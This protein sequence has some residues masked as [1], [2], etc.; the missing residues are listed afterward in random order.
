VRAACAWVAARA[1]SVRIEEE[2]LERYAAELP[3]DDVR[4]APAHSVRVPEGLEP[5]GVAGFVLVLDAINFGSGY[6]PHLR[7]RPGLSGYQTVEAALREWWEREGAPSPRDLCAMRPEAVAEILGQR[8]ADP[9]ARELMGL[10]AR[11]LRDLGRHVEERH[12]GDLAG[13][14][15]SGKGSAAALVRDLCAMPL[16]L[17]IARYEGRP[18][19][20]LKRAQITAHDLAASV[21]GPL[22]HFEDLAELTIFADNL[23]PHVL[24]LDG[25]LAFA[26]QLEDR[27]ER[28]E[29]LAWGSPEE[30]EIR[31]CALDSVERLVQRLR[32][33]GA[34]V[35]ARDLDAWLWSRGQATRY[36]ARPRHRCRCTFY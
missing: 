16:Y 13:P 2:R 22:G 18:V 10:Y 11:A 26:P 31:A 29:L 5:A 19:A 30:V 15:R 35:A 33:R 34:R 21:S 9:V 3:I 20:F 25:V 1:R 24:R 23:V 8:E 32:A 17:D 4:A 7:K 27:I 12:A 36:K 6:F 14:P 28:E